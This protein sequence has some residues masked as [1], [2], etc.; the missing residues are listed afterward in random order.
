MHE[1]LSQ[2]ANTNVRVIPFVLDDM[3][4]SA[5]SLVYIIK[6]Y[7]EEGKGMQAVE[8]F[9]LTVSGLPLSQVAA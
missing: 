2:A 7:V 6:D 1:Q 3:F 8:Q 5:Q 4:Q 9:L